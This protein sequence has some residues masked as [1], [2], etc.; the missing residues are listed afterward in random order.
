[1]V[2]KDYI[3]NG[4]IK[5]RNKKIQYLKKRKR[6]FYLYQYSFFSIIIVI[7]YFILINFYRNK[8][9][10]VFDDFYFFKLNNKIENYFLPPKRPIEKWRYVKAFEN[11]IIN[12][13]N[14]NELNTYY[15]SN[16]YHDTPKYQLFFPITKGLDST[17]TKHIVIDYKKQDFKK[18]DNKKKIKN[19][20]N[21]FLKCGSFKNVTQAELVKANL[22]FLG[23][24]SKIYLEKNGR[25]YVSLGPYN[26]NVAKEIFSQLQ[27]IITNC[28]LQNLKN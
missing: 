10:L 24:E 16:K 7:L 21:I 1:M 15:Y 17:S 28:K 6:R 5:I 25:N 18:K 23:F 22:A 3:R 20:C 12:F 19:K 4:N 11:G 14:L 8:K 2:Q 9:N 13:S 26:K 27:N